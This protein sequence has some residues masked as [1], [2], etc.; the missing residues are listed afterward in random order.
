MKIVSFRPATIIAAASIMV[1]ATGGAPVQPMTAQAASPHGVR[2][3]RAAATPVWNDASIARF[4]SSC[5]ALPGTLADGVQVAWSKSSYWYDGDE[6]SSADQLN[7]ITQRGI[8]TLEVPIKT[9]ADPDEWRQVKEC[10]HYLRQ[11]GTSSLW[12][13]WS[14]YTCGG[15]P[16]GLME[17]IVVK[18]WPCHS[19]G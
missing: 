16:S 19:K 2:L 8:F 13:Q 11:N 7:G 10:F 6:L 1:S 3:I 5:L 14:M 17:D 15:G 18:N 4:L 12:P 9:A